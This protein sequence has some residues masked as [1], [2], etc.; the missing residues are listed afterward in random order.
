MKTV[1]RHDWK[2]LGRGLCSR[3]DESLLQGQVL[4]VP[5]ELV[6][7]EVVAMA[8][9]TPATVLSTIV[10]PVQQ[11][12]KRVCMSVSRAVDWPYVS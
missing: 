2:I 11:I 9:P 3:G 4:D 1:S 10:H 5:A 12:K 7:R 8:I 6:D